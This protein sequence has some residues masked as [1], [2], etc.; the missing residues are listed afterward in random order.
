MNKQTIVFDSSGLTALMN[1][2]DAFY[3]Q[4]YIFG[5]DEAFAKNGYRLLEAAKKQQAA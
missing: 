2:S 3:N 1:E 4:P 5:F